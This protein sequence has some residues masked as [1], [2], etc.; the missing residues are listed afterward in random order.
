MGPGCRLATLPLGPI[1]PPSR[2]SRTARSPSDGRAPSTDADS[3][4]VKG[5]NRRGIRTREGTSHMWMCRAVPLPPPC[6]LI[7]IRSGIFALLCF[8][9]AFD[10]SSR[11][12]RGRIAF[13]FP[14][15]LHESD[16]R[17]YTS[18]CRLGL[19]AREIFPFSSL[20][21]PIAASA[22]RKIARGDDGTALVIN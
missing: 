14:H 11:K 9:F 16:R 19:R 15:A 17:F 10:S 12:E 2:P 6:N 22:P 8:A 7:K 20:L 13:R 21:L 1:H 18:T 4:P 3:D 5:V